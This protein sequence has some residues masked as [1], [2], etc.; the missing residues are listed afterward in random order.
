MKEDGIRGIVYYDIATYYSVDCSDTRMDANGN[1]VDS[2]LNYEEVKD[3][4]QST[5]M[6][7]SRYTRQGGS[8]GNCSNA[9][10]GI[11]SEPAYPKHAI[12]HFSSTSEALADINGTGYVEK[13]YSDPNCDE[14]SFMGANWFSQGICHNSL[15]PNS[16]PQSESF[17]F[18]EQVAA[19]GIVPTK[20]KKFRD[21]NCSTEISMNDG[22]FHV[23]KPIIS[24]DKTACSNVD[25][26]EI[27]SGFVASGNYYFQSGTVTAWGE[28]DLHGPTSAPTFVREEWTQIGEI[29]WSGKRRTRKGGLC[30][31]LCSGHG[32][33]EVNQNC[34]CYVGSH[35][36][37]EWTGPGYSSCL[38]FF[39]D[40]MM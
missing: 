20:L 13:Y 37:P 36:E 8:H 24:F 39:Y 29:T 26:S 5:S 35:G 7:A 10:D 4:L 27:S 38:L 19:G 2:P 12:S 14:S 40:C 25:V 18:V 33:C 22:V 32:I 34:V 3:N 28:S 30:E 23:Q 1:S 15:S 11:S 9:I 31:N 21:E 17:Q 16:I 6:Y